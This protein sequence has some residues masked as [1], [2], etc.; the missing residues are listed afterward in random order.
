MA[1]RECWLR[2]V[3]VLWRLQSE[4]GHLAFDHPWVGALTS[5]RDTT[6]RDIL[7]Q[8]CMKLVKLIKGDHLEFRNSVGDDAQS[9]HKTEPIWVQVGLACSFMH[10]ETDRVMRDEQAV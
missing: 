6:I 7:Q 3:L 9:M 10:Q 2:P 1:E 8:A 5:L 4:V